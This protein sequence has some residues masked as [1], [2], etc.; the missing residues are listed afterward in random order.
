MLLEFCHRETDSDGAYFDELAALGHAHPNIVDPDGGRHPMHNEDRSAWVAFDG[1]IFNHVELRRALEKKGYRF[2]TGSDTELILHLYEDYGK[3]CVHHLNG[4]W[5][6]AVWDTKRRS[7]LLSRDR[8]GIRPLYYTRADGKLLFASEV[9]CLLVHPQV[10]REIDP[11]GLGQVFTLG[12]TLPPRTVFRDVSELPPGHN[13][14]VR[15]E[16]VRLR[17]YWQLC[18]DGGGEAVT[19]D[20]WAEQLGDLLADATRLR[21]KSD[22]PVGVY[23]NGGIG[24]STTAALVG[25]CAGVSPNLFSVALGHAGSHQSGYQRTVVDACGMEHC[26]IP[27]SFDD[28]RHVFPEVIRHVERPVL[29]TAPA[30]WHVLS[31]EVR[32]RGYSVVMTGTGAD[33]ILGGS[34]IFKEVKIRQFCARQPGSRFRALL[35]NELYPQLHNGRNPSAEYL[36]AFFRARP[37][38]LDH[39]LS[40]H[41]RRWE[42]TS[43]LK[44]FFSADLRNQL[45]YHDPYDEVL[46][47]LPDSYDAWDPLGKAQY[48]EL[49]THVG[50]FV[51]SLTGDRGV[52]ANSVEGRSPFLDHR[53]AELAARIPAK[54]KMRGLK[55]GYILKLATEHLLPDGFVGLAKPTRPLSDAA[56]FADNGSHDVRYDDAE[57]LLSSE[58]IMDNGLFCPV[59]VEQLVRKARS[60]RLIGDKDNMALVGI[61][62]TQLVVDQLIRQPA[63]VPSPIPAYP[64]AALGDNQITSEPVR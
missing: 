38:D 36:A 60:G 30:L 40:S 32:D 21:F 49:L 11:L 62:S 16:G 15:P 37:D 34:N 14:V 3:D 13:L 22:T 23:L 52:A 46:E 27:C 42:L 61:L 48:L 41:L 35:F 59:K 2:A 12:A 1:R 31:R 51:L 20:E 57:E 33:E 8:L 26:S 45:A 19:G 4:R 18:C 63:S 9:K 7:L 29:H 6:F 47:I 39:P 58:R 50:S 56:C 64:V 43:R 5:S 24:S 54:L 53:V 55:E 25:Q 44:S 17:R 28:V 10:R